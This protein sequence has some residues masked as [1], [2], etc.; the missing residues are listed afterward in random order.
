MCYE[1]RS[2]DC[3][4][5]A[6]LSQKLISNKDK[7]ELSKMSAEDALE[8]IRNART[9][10][11]F[12]SG[13]ITEMYNVTWCK[14]TQNEE[15]KDALLATGVTFLIDVNDYGDKFW[16]ISEGE[17]EN[18]RGFIL[19]NIRSRLNI[20]EKYG[21]ETYSELSASAFYDMLVDEGLCFDFTTTQYKNNIIDKFID[22]YGHNEL[23]A[24]L[25]PFLLEDN[26]ALNG[27]WD[28][29]I[30]Y[31]SQICEEEL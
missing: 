4:E 9:L 6:Y 12:N 25:L 21:Y 15:L 1:S 7:D 19:M 20:I 31:I 27:E 16:G 24:V 13:K 5:S 29:E 2:Y 18:I 14:F 3:S 26:D 22:I 8:F 11:D 10:K 17:G 23:L 30:D 28:D